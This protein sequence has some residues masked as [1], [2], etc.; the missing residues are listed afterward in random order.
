MY[1]PAT[2]LCWPGATDGG[3]FCVTTMM[4][5][6]SSAPAGGGGVGAGG[7]PGAGACAGGV[8]GA[9]GCVGWLGVQAAKIPADIATTNTIPKILF[10]TC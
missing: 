6:P 8:P 3:S 10:F 5:L 7:V 4:P 2:A 1:D 9:A